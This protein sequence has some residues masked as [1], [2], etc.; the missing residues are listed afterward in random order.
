MMNKQAIEHE[1]ILAQ[2]I[3]A[4]G[5]GLLL[6]ISMLMLWDDLPQ[7]YG[8]DALLPDDLLYLRQDFIIGKQ[9]QLLSDALGG[10]KSLGFL[11]LTLCVLLCF[12]VGGRYLA[13]LLLLLHLSF[14]RSVIFFTYGFDQLATIALF[15]CIMLPSTGF[16]YLLRVHICLIY[17]FAGLD[18]LL[19]ATWW[20]GEALYKA[21]TLPNGHQ[22]LLPLLHWLAQWSLLYKVS[23]IA[24]WLSEITYP[25]FFLL[26]D[27]RYRLWYAIVFHL[28]IAYIMQLYLFSGVMLLLNFA[29]SPP[30]KL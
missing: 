8:T 23:G 2:R 5:L 27:Y 10:V 17:F 1:P 14:F 22:D 13:A 21:L 20:N 6:F 9:L 4:H 7:L 25:L 11:Y 26:K 12:R 3:L 16:I 24:V 19:G 30:R 29:A 28:S 18:K 15:Y